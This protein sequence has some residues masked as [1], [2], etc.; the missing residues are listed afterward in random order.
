ML[1]PLKGQPNRSK[2]KSLTREP[3]NKRLLLMRNARATNDRE[4]REY[5]RKHIP[6]TI[7]SVCV[8]FF[9]FLMSFFSFFFFLL[10]LLLILRNVLLGGEATTAAVGFTDAEATADE[11]PAS[12]PLV[13]VLLSVVAALLPPLDVAQVAWMQRRKGDVIPS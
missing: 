13:L 10:P 6:K 7:A 4:Q 9:S 8:A 2:F 1:L 3:E 5:V 12:R 11:E